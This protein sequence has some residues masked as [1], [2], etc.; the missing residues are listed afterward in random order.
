MT[1]MGTYIFYT[2]EGRT[3]SPDGQEVENCQLLGEANGENA[4]EA[5]SQLLSENPWIESCGFKV[6][7]GNIIARELLNTKRY[8]L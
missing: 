8:T 5:L 1:V 2:L 6:G 4:G 3:E 7:T